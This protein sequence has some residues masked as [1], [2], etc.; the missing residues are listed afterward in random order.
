MNAHGGL[1]LSQGSSAVF[2]DGDFCALDLSFTG[3]AAKLGNQFVNLRQS[4]CSDGMAPRLQTAA[5]IDGNL[6]AESGGA[7]FRQTSAFA[8][9]AETQRF[10]LMQLTEGA[11]VG[12]LGKSISPGPSPDFS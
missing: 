3:F 2:S 9:T 11:G 5:D 10:R 12:N 7:A 6:A 1:F 4:G 8:L